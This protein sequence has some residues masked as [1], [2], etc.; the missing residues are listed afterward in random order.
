MT[1]SPAASPAGHQDLLPAGRGDV[2]DVDVVVD[3][4]DE[5][6]VRA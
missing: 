1:D 4:V 2:A 5:V 3:V 6:V